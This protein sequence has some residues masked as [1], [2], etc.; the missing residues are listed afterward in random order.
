MPGSIVLAHFHPQRTGRLDRFYA[1]LREV[2]RE[3]QG[4]SERELSQ[5]AAAYR[6]ILA[7]AERSGLPFDVSIATGIVIAG[8]VEGG[9]SADSAGL[10]FRLWAGLGDILDKFLAVSALHDYGAKPYSRGD[11]ITIL[12]RLTA[13]GEAAAGTIAEGAHNRTFFRCAFALLPALL[14]C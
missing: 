5:M 11:L 8:A 12:G 10:R 2:R 13:F 7:T 3:G 9:K 1:D 14:G 6:R 4:R